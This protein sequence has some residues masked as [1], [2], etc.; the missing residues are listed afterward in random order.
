[1]VNVKRY[2]VLDYGCIECGEESSVIGFANTVDE[3]LI[4]ADAHK[5]HKWL[6]VD[7]LHSK[8]SDWD[9]GLKDWE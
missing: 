3:A 2:L 9:I 5:N 8:C 4:V 7:L 6:I 1:M